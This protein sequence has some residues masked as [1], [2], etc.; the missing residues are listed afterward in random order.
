MPIE[1]STGLYNCVITFP[2]D[3]NIL[4]GTHNDG[5][6]IVTLNTQVVRLF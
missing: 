1:N 5:K 2:H 6:A 4:N 3:I